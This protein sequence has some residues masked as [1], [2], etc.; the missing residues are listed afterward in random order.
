MKAQKDDFGAFITSA[1]WLDV[2]YGELV[3][4]LFLSRLGG[5]GIT[6]VEPTSRTFSDAQTTSAI[7]QFVIGSRP[8]K[9]YG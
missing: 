6:V 3:R 8:P 2:N 9:E 7:T 4:R 5:Q 1:E